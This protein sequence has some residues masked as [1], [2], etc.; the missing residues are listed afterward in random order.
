MTRPGKGLNP[1]TVTQVRR[2]TYN[3][4]GQTTA[5]THPENGTVN[6]LYNPDGTVQRKT[7]AKGQRTEGT[8]APEGWLDVVRK[9]SAN[10][11]ADD[12]SQ[13]KSEYGRP[14]GGQTVDP[15]FVAANVLGRVAAV[16]TGGQH[17][18]GGRID[19]LYSDNVAGAVLRRR[20]RITRG[21]SIVTTDIDS[22]YTRLGIPV[23][24]NDGAAPRNKG[25]EMDW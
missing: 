13:V 14:S 5:I 18:R 3:A 25:L 17:Q 6:F 12:C 16:S 8:Y 23:A 15:T 9:F 24:G 1:A 21:T 22:H 10:G 11:A 4:N 7:D 19:E 20:T 2:F